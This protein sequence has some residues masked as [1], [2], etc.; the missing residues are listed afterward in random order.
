[1][2]P[3]SDRLFYVN[4]STKTTQWE[5]PTGAGVIPEA[6]VAQAVAIPIATAAALYDAIPVGNLPP[7]W[8]MKVDPATGDPFYINHKMK[9]T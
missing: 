7:G 5:P 9:V 6:Y 8:E 1:M 3:S 2:D 4:H